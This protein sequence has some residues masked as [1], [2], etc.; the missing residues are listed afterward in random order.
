MRLFQAH[1]EQNFTP[2]NET[3]APK[4]QVQKPKFRS[5]SPFNPPIVRKPMK[6]TPYSGDTSEIIKWRIFTRFFLHN[7]AMYSCL[8]L[9]GIRPSFTLSLAGLG[10]YLGVR[11]LCMELYKF[12]NYTVSL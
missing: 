11:W 3:Y 2:P 10:T 5:H 12:H 8:V 6:L 9:A 7:R 4:P 1:K